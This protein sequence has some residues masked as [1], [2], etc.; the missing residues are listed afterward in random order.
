MQGTQKLEGE[1]TMSAGKVV[2]DLNGM[3]RSDWKTL[4]Q[5]DAQVVPRWDGIVQPENRTRR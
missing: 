4:G 3:T 2:W 1:L 5:D